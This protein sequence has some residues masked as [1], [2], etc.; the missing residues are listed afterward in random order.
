MFPDRNVASAL[1]VC[2]HGQYRMRSR[3][4]DGALYGQLLGPF[5]RRVEGIPRHDGWVSDFAAGFTSIID[6]TFDRRGNLYVL[7]IAKERTLAAFGSGDFTALIRV[8]PNGA[9]TEVA[10]EGLF[11][12]GGVAIG[13]LGAA[14]VTNYGI[15][16]GGGQVVRIPLPWPG[17]R[18][19]GT[20][21][22][23]VPGTTW[24]APC[25]GA[26]HYVARTVFR[27]RALRKC[28]HPA[29]VEPPCA[30]PGSAILRIVR[31][32]APGPGSQ[33]EAARPCIAPAPSLYRTCL[34]PIDAGP[35]RKH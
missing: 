6:V 27:C 21:N 9:R 10:S 7:E 19:P 5:T 35:H 22:L 2:P 33:G 4:G 11:A 29:L 16:S 24:H 17:G 20:P 28:R 15:A 3:S 30:K 8:A 32:R 13:G 26:G 25:L 18:I 31:C 1:A 34:F 23:W 12:P 14:C